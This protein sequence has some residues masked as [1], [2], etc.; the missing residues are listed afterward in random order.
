MLGLYFKLFYAMYFCIKMNVYKL[1]ING[2]SFSLG[3]YPLYFVS[4]YDHGF[5]S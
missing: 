2:C 5:S 4:I 3:N 1:S